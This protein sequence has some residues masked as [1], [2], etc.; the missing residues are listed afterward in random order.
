MMTNP[1]MMF[2]MKWILLD[3]LAH[4]EGPLSDR[5]PSCAL[6]KSKESCW[7]KGPGSGQEET[8][9]LGEDLRVYSLDEKL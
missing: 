7:Q 8:C 1:Q 6:C 4:S 5:P 3:M 9:P 2:F